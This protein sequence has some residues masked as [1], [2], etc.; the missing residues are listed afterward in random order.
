MLLSVKH[1]TGHRITASGCSRKCLFGEELTE[2]SPDFFTLRGSQILGVLPAFGQFFSRKYDSLK[3][4]ADSEQ[5][6]LRCLNYADIVTWAF[7]NYA[8]C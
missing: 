5:G 8:H 2:E 6:W 1:S 3:F 4:M 7:A